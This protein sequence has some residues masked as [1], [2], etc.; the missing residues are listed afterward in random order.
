MTTL[1]IA[2]INAI[3]PTAT[4]QKFSDG[5]NGLYLHVSPA[6]GKYW[7]RPF[8]H[9]RKQSTVSIGVYPRVSLKKAREAAFEI[10]KQL[11][12]GENPNELKRAEA[13]KN[14]REQVNTVGILAEMFFEKNPRNW[15]DVHFSKQRSRLDKYILPLLKD[16]P[17]ADLT[18]PDIFNA[19]EDIQARGVIETAYRVRLL[20]S[21][22]LDYG[23]AKQ[24]CDHNVAKATSTRNLKNS[25]TKHYAAP[26]DPV[27]AGPIIRTIDG[28]TGGFTVRAALKLSSLLFLRPKELRTALWEY[29]DFDKCILTIPRQETKNKREDLI[30]PLSRQS[31]KILQ[32]LKPYTIES[33]RIFDNGRRKGASYSDTT[34]RSALRRM[35]ISNEELTPHG[36][37]AMARTMIDEQLKIDPRYIE[38]QLDHVVKDLNGSAYN[39]TAFLSERIEMM[40]TWADYLDEIKQ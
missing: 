14:Q 18:T 31:M 29:V 5:T 36:F 40:Q 37:R 39:R 27:K 13:V 4:L 8:R 24:F 38:K 28:Y 2:R 9:N 12:S 1:S 6:G 26:I 32:R 35:G 33:G 16:T 30:V 20:L 3:Q 7:R 10:T 15:K 23:C 25:T 34:L 21:D 19:L 22:I 17:I 11:D